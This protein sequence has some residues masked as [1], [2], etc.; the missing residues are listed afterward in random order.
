MGLMPQ[1]IVVLLKIIASKDQKW[2]LASLANEIGLS[3]SQVHYAINRC[4]ESRLLVSHDGSVKPMIAN[5]EEF[6]LH[7][8]K[9]MFPPERGEQTRG[10]PTIWAGPPL[11]KYFRSNDL[12]PVWPDAEGQ[13]KGFSFEPIHKSAV[14]GAKKDPQLYE[15][16]VLLDALRDGRARER[17]MA[18]EMLKEKLKEFS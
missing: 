6:L 10:I 5:T 13:A 14:V 4:I 7:G 2:S 12:P 18:V 3:A 16:L 17:N 15:L 9:Y 1:D 11:K 8:V